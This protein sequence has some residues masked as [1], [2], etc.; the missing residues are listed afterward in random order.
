MKTEQKSKMVSVEFYF[1]LD[2]YTWNTNFI[3]VPENIVYGGTPSEN[4]KLIVDWVYKNEK[5][6]KNVAMIG[7]YSIPSEE[8]V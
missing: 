5:L 1:L 4:E 7:V 2:D 6:H 8:E 3:D